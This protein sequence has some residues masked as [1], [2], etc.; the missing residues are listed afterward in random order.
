[1]TWRRIGLKDY[2]LEVGN[3]TSEVAVIHSNGL[4]FLTDCSREY[5][6]ESDAKSNAYHFLRRLLTFKDKDFV[7]DFMNNQPHDPKRRRRIKCEAEEERLA[8]EIYEQFAREVDDHLEKLVPAEK[9]DGEEDHGTEVDFEDFLLEDSDTDEEPPTPEESH[10]FSDLFD[11]FPFEREQEE[12]EIRKRKNNHKKPAPFYG[13]E[14][15]R[16]RMQ[17]LL[18]TSYT[19]PT[20]GQM[21]RRFELL[22]TRQTHPIR[23]PLFCTPNLSMR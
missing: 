21:R 9:Q 2:V 10:A 18:E 20:Y 7:Y 4:I 12:E 22:Q 13:D 19:P 11:F 5:Q 23:R 1:M 16:R 3:D 15:W 8:K 17:K 14:A 6:F